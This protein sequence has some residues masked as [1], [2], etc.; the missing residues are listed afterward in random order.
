MTDVVNIDNTQVI[1]DVQNNN[2]ILEVLPQ[3]SISNILVENTYNNIDIYQ[4]SGTIEISAGESIQGPKGDKG[5]AAATILVGST[6][7]GA[8]GSSASVTNSGTSSDVVLNFTVP[9]GNTGAQGAQGIQ[10][11]KGDTGLT[12]A[13]GATGAQGIQGLKGDTGSQGLKG[14]TGD[15]GPQGIQ[16]IKGDTGNQGLQGIQGIQGEQGIQGIKGDKGDKGDTGND[17]VDGDRYATTSST[18]FT[19]GNSGNQT[20]AVADVNVDYSTGQ[21]IT[22]AYDVSNIQYGTVISYAAGSLVFKKDSYDG[23]GTYAAWSVN[24]SGAVGIQ[25]PQGIQGEPGPQGEQGIQG[26]QGVQ[27]EQGIQGEEGTQATFSI[28]SATPPTSPVNGQAWFNSNNG[29]SYIYYDSYWVEVGSSLSGPAGATGPQG[30]QGLKG[31]TGDTGNT[32]PTGSQGIQGLKGD[33]GNTGATG[34]TGSQGPQGIQGVK[35]DTGATGATGPAGAGTGPW[36]LLGTYQATS[37]FFSSFTGLNGAYKELILTWDGCSC[38]G[39]PINNNYIYIR[40]NGVGGDFSNYTGIAQYY[41][42]G[43]NYG[44]G[45][46]LGQ[47]LTYNY[48]SGFLR[49]TNANSTSAKGYY[50]SHSGLLNS[51]ATSTL[52]MAHQIHSGRFTQASV[53]N[54]IN[55]QVINQS[56]TSGEWNLWGLPA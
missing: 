20:I 2:V 36:T 9:V 8:A 29:K 40:I 53:I 34:A 12:G 25:G 13:T 46:G 22:V 38:G 11:L 14:D 33:T 51:G 44:N 7:T 55:F 43:S 41:F 52:Q 6:T 31:D 24:L 19:L 49:I 48:G 10:G 28:T 21:S 35:G 17:G 47:F 37:S 26:I 39:S 18:S 23:S 15:T 45:G 4:A 32:G 42:N 50:M 3:N 27:G 5:D 54:S 56:W 30:I 1:L 16:G